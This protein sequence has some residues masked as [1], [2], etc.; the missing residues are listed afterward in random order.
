MGKDV[1]VANRS[2]LKDEVIE[3][4]SRGDRE[5]FLQK[6]QLTDS[7]NR[8]INQRIEAVQERFDHTAHSSRLQMQSQL[9]ELEQ[10]RSQLHSQH[11]ERKGKLMERR[12]L[13]DQSMDNRQAQQYIASF[14]NN[15]LPLE[16]AVKR[17]L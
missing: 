14:E 8:E 2:I 13:H 3:T 17:R 4:V 9:H 10:V 5:E 11:S 1:S 12:N 6:L 15:A 16:T 7:R